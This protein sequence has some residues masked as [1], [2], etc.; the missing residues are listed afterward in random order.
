MNLKNQHYFFL[1][2][3]LAISFLGHGLVRL[4]KLHEFS[5]WMVTAMAKSV[6]P[7][8]LI[9][10]FSYFLAIAEAVVGILLLINFK[11][12]YSIYAGLTLMALLVLGSTSIEDWGS[13]VAQLIH[14]IYLVLMLWWY[15]NQVLSKSELT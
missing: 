6:I 4:P 9:V 11:P 15:E 1:R 10:P 3:P 5:S 12:R 13:V 14:S 7:E 2:L 8:F